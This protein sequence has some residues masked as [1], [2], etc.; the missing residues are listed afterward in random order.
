[1]KRGSWSIQS[2]V[3]KLAPVAEAPA[4]R[5]APERPVVATWSGTEGLPLEVDLRGMDVTDALAALD[6]GVDQAVLAGLGEIRVIH[7]IGRGVLRV[8]VEKHLRGHAQ[9]SGQR[10][11]AI[12][13]GGRGV[14]VARLR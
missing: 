12:G 8:A 6:R 4:A 14:T 7:G 2:H 1:L 11:G 10:V 3:R 9:V 5:P 13:E